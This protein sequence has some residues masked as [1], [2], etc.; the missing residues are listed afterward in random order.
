[1]VGLPPEGEFLDEG[2]PRSCPGMRGS[3]TPGPAA[4]C[5]LPEQ[6]LS[7]GGMGRSPSP[8]QTRG[9]CAHHASCH[10]TGLGQPHRHP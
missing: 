9:G 1:M 5:R 2:D 8:S 6:L 3:S 4:A 10:R 7:L